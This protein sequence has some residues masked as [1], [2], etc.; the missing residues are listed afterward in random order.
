MI[1]AIISQMRSNLV[2]ALISSLIVTLPS[3]S[4]DMQPIKNP[5][6][7]QVVPATLKTLLVK[8]KTDEHAYIPGQYYRHNFASQFYLQNSSLV[9]KTFS[10]FVDE[11]KRLI[12]I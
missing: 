10:F 6:S 2:L 4:Q 1:H 9:S 8:D 7:T 5:S 12:K 11:N 3:F